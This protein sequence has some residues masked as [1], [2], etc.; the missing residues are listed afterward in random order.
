[1]L[2][3]PPETPDEAPKRSE[4]VHITDT[5]RER[6]GNWERVITFNYEGEAYDYALAALPGIPGM[7]SGPVTEEDARR[8]LY[9]PKVDDELRNV[10]LKEVSL[11]MTRPH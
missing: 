5:L 1:M 10:F 11:D 9:G 2:T 7:W 4:A 8:R 6:A 3:P